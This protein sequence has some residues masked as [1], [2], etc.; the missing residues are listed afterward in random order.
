MKYCNYF[1][2][3]ENVRSEHLLFMFNAAL[4][5]LKE[6]KL[7]ATKLIRISC[8]GQGRKKHSATRELHGDQ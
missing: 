6:N 4:N 5:L 3:A 2:L 1:L 7:K 8:W